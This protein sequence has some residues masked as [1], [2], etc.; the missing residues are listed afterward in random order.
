M[1]YLVIYSIA[2]TILALIFAHKCGSLHEDV[3]RAKNTKNNESQYREKYFK[4]IDNVSNIFIRLDN[5]IEE[6][7]NTYSNTQLKANPDLTYIFTPQ[8]VTKPAFDIIDLDNV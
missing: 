3:E 7:N 4:L 6:F 1:I 2:I 8:D 5:S